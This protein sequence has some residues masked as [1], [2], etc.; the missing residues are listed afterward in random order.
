LDR[1]PWILD[2]RQVCLLPLGQRQP[3]K[4]EILRTDASC[5][6]IA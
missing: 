1:Q 2:L 3:Y 6:G 4:L 5:S